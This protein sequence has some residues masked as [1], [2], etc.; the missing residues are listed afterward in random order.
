[1]L[2]TSLVSVYITYYGLAG[3]QY[4]SSADGIDFGLTEQVVPR[5]QYIQR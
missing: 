5:L 3:S 1:M 2:D 4:V